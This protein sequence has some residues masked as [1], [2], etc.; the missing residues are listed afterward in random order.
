[1]NFLRHLKMHLE[2][3]L[4]TDN[5]T[6]LELAFHYFKLHDADKNQM[7]DGLELIQFIIHYAEHG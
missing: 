7:L 3:P 6:P 2:I 5:M 4:E 1:M